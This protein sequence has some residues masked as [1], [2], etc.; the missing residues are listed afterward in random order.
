[1]LDPG[2]ARAGTTYKMV[3][4]DAD[5]NTLTVNVS[6]PYFASIPE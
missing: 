6:I 4:T 2:S 1:M 3:I 5:P